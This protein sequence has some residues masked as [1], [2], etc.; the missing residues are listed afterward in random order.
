[1]A[2]IQRADQAGV[3]SV[4]LTAGGLVWGLLAFKPVWALAFFFVPLLTA[5]LNEVMS[6]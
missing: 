1:M 5:R 6:K 4:W 3:L 2:L